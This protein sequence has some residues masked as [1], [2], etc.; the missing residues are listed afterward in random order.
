MALGLVEPSERPTGPDMVRSVRS[1]AAGAGESS[2]R[3][4]DP[5]PRR[6]TRCRS[7]TPRALPPFMETVLLFMG[8]VQL[9]TAALDCDAEGRA[10]PDAWQ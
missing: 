1:A 2:S 8:A 7:L 6:T 5:S 3:D 4:Q 10:V 9:F